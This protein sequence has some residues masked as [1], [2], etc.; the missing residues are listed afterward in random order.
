MTENYNEFGA[1]GA[2]VFI[3]IS[4]GMLST[5]HSRE[6]IVAFQEKGD[7][8]GCNHDERNCNERDG[9]VHDWVYVD[10]LNEGAFKDY[11]PPG[12]PFHLILSPDGTV[13]WNSA[14]HEQGD[15]LHEASDA[16]RHHLSGG[17]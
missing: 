9:N 7:Y 2:A 16:L 17:A 5:D 3:T 6:E 11:N 8:Q 12:V 4:V 14:M 10:D 15:P 13:V 1:N